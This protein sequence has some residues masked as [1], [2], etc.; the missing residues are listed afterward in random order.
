MVKRADAGG[1]TCKAPMTIAVFGL[2]YV[3]TVTAGCLAA[4]GHSVIGVDISD[5]K[6]DLINRGISPIREP[7]T[8][9]LIRENVEAGRLRATT[10]AAGVIAACDLS[11]V[12]VGTPSARDGRPDYQHIERVTRTIGLDLGTDRRHTVAI[13]STILPGTAAELIVPSLERVSGLTAGEDFGFAHIPEFLREGTAIRDYLSPP[14]TVIGTDDPRSAAL[15]ESL[16]ETLPGPRFTVPVAVA[17][18]VKFTDNVW[19]ALKVGFGNEVGSICKSIGIDSHE[20]MN[21]FCQDTKLNISRNY[22][23]PGFAFGGSCLPKDTRGFSFLAR[24]NGVEVPIINSI[25]DSNSRH[26]QRA[27]DRILDTGLRRVGVL[28]CSFKPFTDDLRESPVL[29]LIER[30]LGKGLDVCVYDP[31]VE[32]EKLLG[33]NR[34]F[35]LEKIPHIASIMVPSMRDLV[36]HSDLIVVGTNDPR[37][38]DLP[39]MLH[40]QQSVIDLVRLK[41]APSKG[42]YDGIC[43]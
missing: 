13:R 32:A 42:S 2:G 21:I 39:S 36:D 23:T 25:L 33:A 34:N 41:A 43:W 40:D 5:A 18:A 31:N 19:H 10:D 20:V 26:V 14:K 28:G 16:F 9:D 4:E 27:L 22:L 6:V 30:L 24:T 38:A 12:C 17:E 3:G 29:E 35:A 37:F 7:G 8:D 15:L 11:I 1:A